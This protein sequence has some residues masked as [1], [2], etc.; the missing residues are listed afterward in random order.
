M[1]VTVERQRFCPVCDRLF[2]EG[3]AVLRCGSCRVLHHP[4]CWVKNNGC[5]TDGPHDARPQPEAYAIP[6][7][8]EPLPVGAAPRPAPARAATP[9]A[10]SH[11]EYVIGRESPPLRQVEAPA[12]PP[13]VSRPHAKAE[14][15]PNLARTAYSKRMPSIY[16]GHR[17]LRFWYVPAAILLAGV[18]ALTVIWG[19]DRFFG[20]DGAVAAPG[21]KPQATPTQAAAAA[22]TATGQPQATP[23][24]TSG[25]ATGTATPAATEPAGLAAG[26]SAVVTGTGGCL[27][28]RTGAGLTNDVVACAPDGTS[29]TVTGGP[30]EADGF[31]WWQVETP[32]GD[33]WVAE[34]YIAA[35]GASAE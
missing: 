34:E 8:S 21:D 10:N 11:D 30:S 6:V 12:A 27:N 32:L 4:G 16:P 23:T 24:P 7:R 35:G 15:Y 25:S 17:Y 20:E 1:S 18:V 5:A 22:A 19:V 13:A 9:V 14:R 31:T 28:V 33:G 26:G 2:N 29:V 3:E